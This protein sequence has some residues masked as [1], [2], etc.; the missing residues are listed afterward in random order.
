MVIYLSTNLYIRQRIELV[1][2]L[3]PQCQEELVDATK[4]QRERLLE[5]AQRISERFLE[6]IV[7]V[8]PRRTEEIVKVIEMRGAGIPP[9][10][11][12]PKQLERSTCVLE[13]PAVGPIRQLAHPGARLVLFGRDAGGRRGVEGGIPV[14]ATIRVSVPA[15]PFTVKFM[16]R[17]LCACMPTCSALMSASTVAHQRFLVTSGGHFTHPQSTKCKPDAATPCQRLLGRTTC[18]QR[19]L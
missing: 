15:H 1:D 19:E 16:F 13:G 12:T 7:Y 9:A 11:S 8:L 3:V 2:A 4:I 17:Y 10:L 18:C 5:R 14:K 6:Q